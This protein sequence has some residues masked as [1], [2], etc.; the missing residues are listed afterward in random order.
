MEVGAT[1]ISVQSLGK[2]YMIQQDR[3]NRSSSLRDTIA[4]GLAR[5]VR[6]GLRSGDGTRKH[7]FFGGGRLDS[8]QFWALRDVSFDVRRGEVVGIVGRNGAGKSTLLKLLSQITEPTEGRIH[9]RGRMSSLL[10][11]GTGFHPE[12]SGRENIFLNGAMLGMSRAEVR[13]KFDDIVAF[14]EIEQF[15]DTPVKR[16]SSGMYVRLAFAV[17]AHLEPEILVVDEVLAV[18]DSAF[19][20]KSLG[21]MDEVAHSGRTVL[22]VS[23]N[24]AA[25]QR[26]CSRALLLQEGRLIEDGAVTSV[27]TRYNGI[28]Q[29]SVES[30]FDPSQRSGT[31]WARVTDMRMV[32]ASGSA[33]METPS[34]ADLRIEIQ[35]SVTNDVSAGTSLKG[36]V[37]ELMFFN[38][39][40]QPLT[41]VMNV[42]DPGVGLP[43]APFCK[44]LM[45]LPGPTFVP[46]RYSISLMLGIPFLQHVDEIASAFTFE[47]VPPHAPWRPYDL[48]DIRGN[49]C[50]KAE[51]TVA[52]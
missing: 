8:A 30:R 13:R 36:L 43:D 7:R 3:R 49:F 44:V 37:L 41:S 23:H 38:D 19:Q 11:V 48:S 1:T 20:K 34:D 29:R 16:Y 33:T 42:D 26:L 24:M 9:L 2:M 32:D 21:K 28:T 5:T 31:G 15:L 6:S 51:W 17:A 45:R 52:E 10:E 4:D 18:G 50:V 27:V 47:I 39:Q 12:L 14:A 40:G 22:F 35:L 25:I 46:G